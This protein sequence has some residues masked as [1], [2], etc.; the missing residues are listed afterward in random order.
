MNVFKT[1]KGHPSTTKESEIMNS[2]KADLRKNQIKYLEMRR[3][4]KL[5]NLSN[6][7]NRRRSTTEKRAGKP[8][9]KIEGLSQNAAERDQAKEKRGN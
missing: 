5:C 6:G 7:P 8:G 3:I 1:K 4:I 9:K 2:G